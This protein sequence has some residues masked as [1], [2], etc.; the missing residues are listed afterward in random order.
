LVISDLRA[1]YGRGRLRSLKWLLDPY[2]AAGVYLLL[3]AFVL[4]R[5][6]PAP[7]LSIA[8]AIVPF[9]LVM[10]TTINGL[11]SVQLRGSIIVNMS[12]RRLLIPVASAVTESIA[13]TASL[14]LLALMMA[15]YGVAPTTAVAWLPLVLLVT[16]VFALALAYPAALVGL[17]YQEVNNFIISGVRT[18]FFLAAGV[19][20]LGQTHGGAHLMLSLNPLT[21]IFESYRDV[22]LYGQAP[23]AWELLYP[24]GV[25]ALLLGGFVRL[26][27]REQ[28]QFAKVIE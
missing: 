3:I 28:S 6:G 4:H 7:G 17:W 12:F 1:R 16:F 14:T 5:Q 15:I 8:C 18:A 19:V 22:L 24:V 9:Q 27:N 13:F 10:A 20:A 21:A 2:A 23:A 11:T 25:A 26:F